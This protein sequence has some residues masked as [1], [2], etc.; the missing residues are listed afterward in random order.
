MTAE[1]QR[2]SSVNPDLDWSQVRETVLMLN[3]ASAQV[4]Y[5]LRDGDQS[6]DV[7]TESFTAMA[8]G[9]REIEEIAA[10]QPASAESERLMHHCTDLGD[11]ANQAIVAFQFYDKLVQRLD[12]VVSCITELGELVS[13]SG[14]LYSPLEWKT[15]QDRIRERYTMKQERE[16][17]DSMLEGGDIN[18][19]LARMEALSEQPE[20]EHDI[21]LF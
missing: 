8:T 6:V 2:S 5:S 16:L 21:E 18:Q 17:F 15:L 7:L 3:L 13:D 10:L 4:I 12:H 20:D 1:Q 19:A 14:R 9:I 11:K